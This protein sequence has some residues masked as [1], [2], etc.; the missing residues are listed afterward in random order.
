VALVAYTILST[1]KAA[2]SSEHGAETVEE[3]VSGYY[4]A[5]EIEMTHRGMMIAIEEEEW[6]VFRTATPTQLVRLLKQLARNVKMSKYLKHP[7]GPKKPKV[8]PKSDPKKPHVSTAKLIA[9]R[10]K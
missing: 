2:L 1:I 9:E 10:K 4:L 5:D 3:K 6:L 8:K 7:R